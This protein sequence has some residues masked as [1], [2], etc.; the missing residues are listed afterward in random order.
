M[1]GDWLLELLI[2][3]DWLSSILIPG[4]WLWDI[5][6][7]GDWLL[8]LLT[9]NLHL[10][11]FLIPGDWRLGGGVYPPLSMGYLIC[12]TKIHLLWLCEPC[13]TTLGM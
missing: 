13:R 2:I 7:L 10:L 11:V 6:I 3:G 4:D 1:P 12:V 8:K 5:L 9:L